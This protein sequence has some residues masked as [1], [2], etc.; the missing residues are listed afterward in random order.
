M[1]QIARTEFLLQPLQHPEDGE[2]FRRGVSPAGRRGNQGAEGLDFVEKPLHPL[3]L[4][5]LP[6]GHRQLQV[7]AELVD[8]VTVAGALLADIEAGQAEGKG[9]DLAEQVIE[10]FAAEPGGLEAVANQFKVGAEFLHRGI[11]Q[12]LTCLEG[13]LRGRLQP[14]AHSNPL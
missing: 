7:A 1:R 3:G 6:V 8:G 4:V 12:L 10:G 13:S 5:H 14:E 2:G 11:V 9:M